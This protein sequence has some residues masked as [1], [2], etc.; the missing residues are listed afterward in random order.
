L[1]SDQ[2][3]LIETQQQLNQALDGM[4]G[5]LS[6][7]TEFIR[8]RTYYPQLCLLQISDATTAVCVDCLAD[9]DLAERREKLLE[10]APVLMHSGRQDLEI[11]W[12]QL[13]QL[14]TTLIDTQI[15]AGLLGMAPQIGYGELVENRLSVKLDKSNSRRDWTLRPLPADALQYALDD[16]HYLQPLWELLAAELDRLGRLEWFAEDCQRQ[17]NPESFD[18]P[19]QI[20]VK[21]KGLGRLAADRQAHAY[22]LVLW[23]EQHAQQLDRPRRWV[24]SDG[25][26]LQIAADEPKT[27]AQL[28]DI[29]EVGSGLVRRQGEQLLE[30]LAS[31]ATAPAVEV[32]RSL[33]PDQRR[34]VKTL[35]QRVAQIAQQL[36]MRPEVLATRGDLETLVRGGRPERLASGWRHQWLTKAGLL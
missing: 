29:P 19:K 34:Q 3:P 26:L 25:A 21:L 36:D 8:E 11:L 33:D 10:P 22:R 35:V 6:L 14:P 1:T 15:A 20:F 30:Q 31:P 2:Q 16:V 32:P 5:P 17:L 13:G 23:R 7:D 24:L 18:D 28:G 12:Q 9:L 27:L 4:T